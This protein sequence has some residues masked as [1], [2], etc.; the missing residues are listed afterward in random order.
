MYRLGVHTKRL[1]KA[2][3]ELMP[4]AKS[5]LAGF[6]PAPLLAALG[7][8]SIVYLPLVSMPAFLAGPMPG[9]IRPVLFYSPDCTECQKSMTLVPALTRRMAWQEPLLVD[10]RLVANEMLRERFDDSFRVSTSFRGHI[11]ALFYAGGYVIGQQ[12]LRSLLSNYVH[13]RRQ[14]A[15]TS[16][17]V[18][19][20]A[21]WTDFLLA[22]VCLIILSGL[23]GPNGRPAF[24]AGLM[25]LAL[26]LCGSAASKL[27]HPA[28][29]AHQAQEMRLGLPTAAPLVRL[30]GAG[31]LALALVPL[32]ERWR[33]RG[34]LAISYLFGVL[35]AFMVILLV[36]HYSGNCGCLPWKD[37]FGWWSLLRDMALLAMCIALCTRALP[38]RPG[39]QTPDSRYVHR[40]RLPDCLGTSASAD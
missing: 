8:A 37:G 16:S 21:R 24:A 38:N 28:L 5:L 33:K 19:P 3:S 11:P 2:A 7:I 30:F 18:F 31:E 34:L 26:V 32:T 22:G 27:L 29:F 17:G 40:R 13:L 4:G 1:I 25:V 35:C 14:S 9:Q 12:N 39:S 23:R 20:F 36:R 15:Y 6:T 10:S